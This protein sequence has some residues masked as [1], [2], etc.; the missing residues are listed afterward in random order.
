MICDLI[1]L[2]V[3][4]Y[5]GSGGTR[6]STLEDQAGGFDDYNLD[7]F[8][9]LHHVQTQDELRGSHLGGAPPT[10]SQEGAGT[11]LG[12]SQL[13]DA[14]GGAQP[15]LGGSPGSY[16]EVPGLSAAMETPHATAD[17]RR[18][19]IHPRDLLTYPRDQTRAAV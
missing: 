6:D 17:A 7:M 1:I 15:S 4:A 2:F 8:D 5:V 9:F 13:P 10:W 11:Q 18:R 19:H 3:L 14:S 16:H 12:G